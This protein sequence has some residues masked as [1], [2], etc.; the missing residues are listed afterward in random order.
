MLL[1][2]TEAETLLKE[3][4]KSLHSLYQEHKK[5]L[6]DSHQQ[7]F[8]R[9][10]ELLDK[11]KARIPQFYGLWKV[12][13]D[14]DSVRPVISCYGSR[15]QLFSTYV[16]YWLNKIIREILPSYLPNVETL[17]ESLKTQFPTGLPA[18]ARLFSIW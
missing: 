11:Q 17:I 15:P 16:N 6:S 2:G 14:K 13:K 4:S 5:D 10:F 3:Q 1:S 8:D 9:S 18:G 12:H 7:Y